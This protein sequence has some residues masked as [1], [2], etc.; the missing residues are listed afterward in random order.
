M[1]HNFNG[2]VREVITNHVSRTRDY[3]QK[4]EAV[5]VDE[6]TEMLPFGDELIYLLVGLK[7][8]KE[9]EEFFE[10]HASTIIYDHRFKPEEVYDKLIQLKE[11]QEVQDVDNDLTAYHKFMDILIE[12]GIFSK[13]ETNG[14]VWY[15][16]E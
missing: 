3:H 16:Y 10:S 4:L 14:E 5:G 15:R 13:H 12:Y 2:D 8:D 9:G 6:I 7:P 1:R 11:L